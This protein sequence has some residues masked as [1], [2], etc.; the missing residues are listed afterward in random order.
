MNARPNWKLAEYSL[1][2]GGRGS[3]PSRI[4][5]FLMQAGFRVNEPEFRAV[6]EVLWGTAMPNSTAA[7]IFV[8]LWYASPEQAVAAGMDHV[9]E[10]L[11]GLKEDQGAGELVDMLEGRVRS[12]V[13]DCGKIL[14]ARQRDLFAF[15]GSRRLVAVV[16]SLQ[17]DDITIASL[18]EA[19]SLVAKEPMGIPT[20][21]SMLASGHEGFDRTLAMD[22]H[23]WS[24]VLRSDFIGMLDNEAGVISDPVKFLETFP[25]ALGS[26]EWEEALA[27]ELADRHE[28]GFPEQAPRQRWEAAAACFAKPDCTATAS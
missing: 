26:K 18:R 17:C 19:I 3:V 8:A 6:H 10:L 24:P 28:G 14:V 9:M 12:L 25:E 1:L 27:V 7:H 23:R 21:R 11:G 4:D 20:F 22:W 2:A 13:Q 16:S 15:V 5:T